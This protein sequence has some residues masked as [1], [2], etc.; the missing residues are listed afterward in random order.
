MNPNLKEDLKTLGWIGLFAAVTA[1]CLWVLL[2][3]WASAHREETA[4]LASDPAVTYDVPAPDPGLTLAFQVH[5]RAEPP[6]TVQPPPKRSSQ[7]PD[8]RRG[9]SALTREEV[10]RVAAE[11]F[12]AKWKQKW[13]AIRSPLPDVRQRGGR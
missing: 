2:S 8:G 1:I 7:E 10:R 5:Q 9:D 3:I 12:E 11:V 4:F 6:H 13:G